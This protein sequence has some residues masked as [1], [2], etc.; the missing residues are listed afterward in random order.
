[1]PA[2][3]P[4]DELTVPLVFALAGE[5]DPPEVD[6]PWVEDGALEHAAATPRGSAARAAPDRP[7]NRR[8][9]TVFEM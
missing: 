4:D 9:L 5:L 7:R 8:R 2:D 3:A 1:M 6:G